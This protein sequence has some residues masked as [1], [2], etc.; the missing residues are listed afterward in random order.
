MASCPRRKT[1]QIVTGKLTYLRFH[2]P[3]GTYRNG[4]SNKVLASWAS[5]IRE[6]N[7]E[8]IEVYA[9]FNNDIGGFAPHNALTLIDLVNK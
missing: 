6:W 7:K 3:Q 4:Y 9:Y 2:E 8:G 1:P 5:R